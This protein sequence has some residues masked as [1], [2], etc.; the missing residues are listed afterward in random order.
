MG[1][2]SRTF[3]AVPPEDAAEASGALSGKGATEPFSAPG[4]CE[5]PM[6]R[7]NPEV[8]ES[9]RELVCLLDMAARL[10]SQHLKQQS[11]QES[12]SLPQKSSFPGKQVLLAHG[13]QA[14]EGALEAP[15]T[16]VNPPAGSVPV[17]RGPSKADYCSQKEEQAWNGAPWGW[18]SMPA[19]LS[20]PRDSTE[21]EPDQQ[22]AMKNSN[23]HDAEMTE[24]L[25]SPFPPAQAIELPKML[26]NA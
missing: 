14:D 23:R 21:I 4:A 15:D 13:T 18:P 1:K 20:S 6:E 16:W 9:Q 17:D 19:G 11:Q 24:G 2:L 7:E 12:G 10:E 26:L 25:E 8:D 22:T 3:R 5:E